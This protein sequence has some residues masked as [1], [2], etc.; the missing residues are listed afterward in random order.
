MVADQFFY[1]QF[2]SCFSSGY[3]FRQDYFLVANEGVKN[4][5]PLTNFIL[6]EIADCFTLIVKCLV[7]NYSNL[8]S[9]SNTLVLNYLI[10]KSLFRLKLLLNTSALIKEVPYEFSSYSASYWK[11]GVRKL[12]MI[13]DVSLWACKH[14]KKYRS[15]V[16]LLKCQKLCVLTLY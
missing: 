5:I 12:L 14:I 1:F 10:T 2:E 6:H 11:M 16:V 15:W 7:M 4:S 3:H 9:T 13:T 8:L